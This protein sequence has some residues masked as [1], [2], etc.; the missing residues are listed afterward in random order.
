MFASVQLSEE[1]NLKTVSIDTCGHAPTRMRIA[2]MNPSDKDY[3][4]RNET[5]AIDPPL[6]HEEE[7]EH[8]STDDEEKQSAEEREFPEVEENGETKEETEV[9]TKEAMLRVTGG[10]P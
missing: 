1:N 8:S 3:T 5:Q 2:R 9:V 4:H 10:Q 6:I 7:I